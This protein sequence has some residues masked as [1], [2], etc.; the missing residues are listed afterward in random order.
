MKVFIGIILLIVG[1]FFMYD[2]WDIKQTS[3]AEIEK[4]IST[5]VQNV[6]NEQ[7]AED[8]NTEANIKLFGGGIAALAGFALIYVGSKNG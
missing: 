7:L 8:R 3:G 5:S 6:S 4:K 1:L 2:G